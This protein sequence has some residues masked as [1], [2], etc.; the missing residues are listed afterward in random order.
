MEVDAEEI[1]PNLDNPL[2]DVRNFPL[3]IIHLN[4]VSQ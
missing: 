1:V 4:I 2:I 3:Y